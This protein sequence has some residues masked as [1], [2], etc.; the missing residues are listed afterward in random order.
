[1]NQED[2]KIEITL[3]P[4]T[5]EDKYDIRTSVL[6]RQFLQKRRILAAVTAFALIAG[7]AFGLVDMNYPKFEG[8]EYLSQR[9]N[10]LWL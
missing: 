6:G 1:M 8:T 10:L 4:Q 2:R 9:Q 7:L 5:E 3:K